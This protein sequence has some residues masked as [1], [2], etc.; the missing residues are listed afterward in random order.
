MTYAAS[1]DFPSV[2]WPLSAASSLS[3]SHVSRAL[4]S[5]GATSADPDPALVSSSSGLVAEPVWDEPVPC[6]YAT[7]VPIL[8]TAS[9]QIARDVT[10]HKRYHARGYS[11]RV[12]AEPPAHARRHARHGDPDAGAGRRSPLTDQQ[13]RR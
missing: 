11:R 10:T 4:G 12:H 3:C 2:G 13:L 8:T 6:E 1:F 5:F 9:T 7:P